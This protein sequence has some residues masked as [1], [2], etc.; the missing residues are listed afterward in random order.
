MHWSDRRKVGRG[1]EYN[2]RIAM[3]LNWIAINGIRVVKKFKRRGPNN[4]CSC[5][6]LLWI[7][8]Y[9]IHLWMRACLSTLHNTFSVKLYLVNWMVCLRHKGVMTGIRRRRRRRRNFIWPQIGKC[10]MHHIII[11]LQQYTHTHIHG[12][13]C[14]DIHHRNKIIN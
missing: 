2:E 1:A 11:K 4:C 12:H 13:M 14:I 7:G 10:T 8:I 3:A 5:G 6:V 9:V